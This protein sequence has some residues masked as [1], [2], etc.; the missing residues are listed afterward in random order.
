[1]NIE[2]NYIFSATTAPEDLFARK[3][4]INRELWF[5]LSKSRSRHCLEFVNKIAK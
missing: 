1:M 5:Y 4:S 3:S 2:A